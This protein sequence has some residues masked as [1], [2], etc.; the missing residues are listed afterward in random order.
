MKK[1]Y[2]RGYQEKHSS[3]GKWHRKKGGGWDLQNQVQHTQEN[4]AKQD[5][6]CDKEVSILVG[7]AYYVWQLISCHL[8]LLGTTVPVKVSKSHKLLPLRCATL[9]EF[10]HFYLITLHFGYLR[11]EGT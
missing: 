6:V 11:S 5:K 8:S 10:I 2:I 4:A 7:I 9:Q 1:E 3:H